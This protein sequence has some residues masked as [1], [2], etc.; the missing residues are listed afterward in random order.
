MDFAN[1]LD[2]EEGLRVIAEARAFVAR[3]PKGSLRTLVDVEGS[4]FDT[5]VTHALKDLAMHNTPYTIAS[6]IVGLSGLHRVVLTAVTTFS[7]REIKS[8]ASV[9]AAKAWLVEQD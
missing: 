3:Q 7:K 9:N 6:A 8:F 4:R 1:V 2:P 5:R